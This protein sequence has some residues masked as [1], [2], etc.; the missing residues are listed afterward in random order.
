MKHFVALTIAALTLA[1]L[2]GAEA[3]GPAKPPAVN[4]A[5]P[6]TS[7]LVY[8]V[9]R[10]GSAIGKTTVDIERNGDTATVK[11]ATNIEVKVMFVVAY[12]FKSTSTEVWKGDQIV[13]FKCETDDNGKSH[14]V[15]IMPAAKG[16]TIVA[17]G[18]TANVPAGTLPASFWS[19]RA[20]KAKALINH[21][22]GRVLNVT[23]K[24]LGPEQITLHGTPLQTQHY[25]VD[26]GKDFQRDIWFEGDQLVRLRLKGTD[27]S[28]ISSDLQS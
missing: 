22:D 6:A 28:A 7:H 25:K 3:A 5:A 18:K 15:S 26:G 19:P 23:S 20:M 14:D 11:S 16:L 2:G 21:D 17:D 24:D 12:R 1:G 9:S 27:G 13:S 8:V 4:A 10:D